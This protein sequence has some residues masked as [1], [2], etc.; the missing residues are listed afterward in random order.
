MDHPGSF[1]DKK[2]FA[3]VFW[4]DSVKM[5]ATVNGSGIRPLNPQAIHPEKLG[6][7]VPYATSVLRCNPATSSAPSATANNE[8]LLQAHLK[9]DTLQLFSERYKEGYDV[10]QDELYKVWKTLTLRKCFLTHGRSTRSFEN[11]PVD[12]VLPKSQ[13]YISPVLEEVLTYPNPPCKPQR[14]TQC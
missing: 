8:L 12:K 11:S 6:P 2:V 10:E 14:T 13:Q 7:A 1:V 3:E 5:S 4:I 9:P